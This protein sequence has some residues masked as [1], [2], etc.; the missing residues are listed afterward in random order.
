[1]P[2]HRLY[3]PLPHGAT[4]T[5]FRTDGPYVRFDHHKKTAPGRGILYAAED[6]KGGL[7][8]VFQAGGGIANTVRYCGLD[9]TRP[10]VLLDLRSDNASMAGANQNICSCAHRSSRPWSRLFYE[11]H[12][13]YRPDLDGLIYPN[14]HNG[15]TAIALYERAMDAIGKKPLWDY[16][17]RERHCRITMLLA[18]RAANLAVLLV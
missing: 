11:E 15:Q 10:L 3:D 7:V 9:V 6:L 18:L 5:G 4:A 16:E 13:L 2:L 12:R 14:S 1:L 8:E 17:I